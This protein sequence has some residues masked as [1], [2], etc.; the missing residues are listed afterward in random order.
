MVDLVVSDLTVEYQS[1]DYVIRPLDR[2]NMQAEAGSLT[3]LL[4][5]SGCGKTTLLSCLAGILRPTTGLDL[6]PGTEVTRSRVG[7]DRLSSPQRR[8]GIPGIQS[9]PEPVGHRQ[10]RC[11]PVGGRGPGR[12]GPQAGRG[13][14]DPCGTEG[15][16]APP[17]WRP[18][19]R[20]AATGGDR[21]GPGSGPAA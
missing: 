11:S 19:R 17:S 20:P 6:L 7:L 9:H 16:H 14:V 10:R 15:P 5:P 4:G 18:V 12:E 21:P 2:L 13:A 8:C 3:L 1:G